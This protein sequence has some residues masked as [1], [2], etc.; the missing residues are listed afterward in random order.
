MVEQT[1]SAAVN[2]SDRMSAEERR[3][4][5]INIALDLLRESGMEAITIGAVAEL[6]GV[7]RTLVYK[8]FAN[9]QDVINAVYQREAAK[10]HVT[11]R[12]RVVEATGFEGRL[13]AFV[14]AIIGAVDTHGWLFSP[15]ES[16]THEAGFRTEQAGRDRRTVREFAKLAGAEFG[17][18]LR[19]ATSA[20]GILLSGLTSLRLQAHVLTSEA[21][22][23]A[24]AALYVDL[25]MA[26]LKGLASGE[27]HYKGD[28]ETSPGGASG[29]AAPDQPSPPPGAR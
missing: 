25:V 24:L 8:H 7:T 22:R 28:T 6:A 1:K 11:I 16:Q 4:D 2:T 23:A 9:R 14:D 10:L 29:D 26:A 18:S 5:L 15:A 27:G 19:E 21:D 20:M 3:D 17:L 13:R 12:D